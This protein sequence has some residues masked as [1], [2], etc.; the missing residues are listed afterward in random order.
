M[1]PIKLFSCL[2]KLGGDSFSMAS[3]FLTRSFVPSLLMLN[4][5]HSTFLHANL[6]LSQD[7]ASFSTSC[8]LRTD[9]KFFL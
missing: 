9:C 1:E 7:I 5:N 2:K 6:D 8:F 4:P 3:V